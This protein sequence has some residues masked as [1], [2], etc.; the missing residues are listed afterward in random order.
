M[1]RMTRRT[2]GIALGLTLGWL[3]A[4]YIPAS[5][6]T[7][8]G[9]PTYGHVEHGADTGEH[10]HEATSANQLVP[11]HGDAPFQ[12]TVL[13]L[14]GGLFAG[15]CVVGLCLRAL[16]ENDPAIV[17]TEQDLVEAAHPHP[18]EKEHGDAHGHAVDGLHG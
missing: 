10:K 4:G 5:F 6:D 17:A 7:P 13:W 12:H 1:K 14:I 18:D 15:A 11:H 16:G 3:A 2:L 8:A 9:T